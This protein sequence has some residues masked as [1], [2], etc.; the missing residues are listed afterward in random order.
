MRYKIPRF[1]LFSR[2]V[3]ASSLIEGNLILPPV[4]LRPDVHVFCCFELRSGFSISGRLRRQ[5]FKREKLIRTPTCLI[6]PYGSLWSMLRLA[7]TSSVSARNS[8]FVEAK[9][10]RIT[11]F[12]TR[13]P[14]KFCGKSDQK[15]D[16]AEKF[17]F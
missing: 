10:Y 3:Y 17:N 16:T 14:Y 8:S 7:R 12:F 11:R 1:R 15:S 13:L 9:R 6:E 4:R 2:A 5:R